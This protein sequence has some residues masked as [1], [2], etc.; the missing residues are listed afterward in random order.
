MSSFKIPTPE[1][2]DCYETNLLD[3]YIQEIKERILKKDFKF[4]KY[5]KISDFI[6]K[7]NKIISE[8]GWKITEVTEGLKEDYHVYYEI[9]PLKNRS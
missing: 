1:E 6:P 7:I 4:T 9:K 3:R 2:I 8:F 5:D